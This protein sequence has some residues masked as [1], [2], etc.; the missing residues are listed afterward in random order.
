LNVSDNPPPPIEV[1]LPPF[2]NTT[3]RLF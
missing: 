2:V 1:N 3:M